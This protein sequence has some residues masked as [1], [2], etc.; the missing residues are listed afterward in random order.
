MNK[1]LA[2]IKCYDILARMSRT[3][4]H[5]YSRTRCTRRQHGGFLNEKLKEFYYAIILNNL[6]KIKKLVEEDGVNVNSLFEGRPLLFTCIQYERF[7]IAKYMIDHGADINFKHENKTILSLASLLNITKSVKFLISNGA[8]INDTNNILGNPPLYNAIFNNNKKLVTW[9]IESGANLNIQNMR[10]ETPLHCAA[11]NGRL[12]IVKMLIQKGASPNIKDNLRMT[13]LEDA[14]LNSHRKIVQYLR[15][16]TA[17]N[18]DSNSNSNNN[19][20]NNNNGP[21][22]PLPAISASPLPTTL[23]ADKPSQCFDPIMLESSNISDN[24]DSLKLY[25]KNRAGAIIKAYCIDDAL[26][27]NIKSVEQLFYQCKDKTPV[28]ALMIQQKNVHVE[29][30]LRRIMMDIPYF[31]TND[32]CQ[33]MQLGKSYLLQETDKPVG[34]IV[35]YRVLNGGNVVSAKHCGPAEPGN[36]YD[37]YEIVS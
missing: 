1:L 32:E 5:R 6:K 9:L 8:D 18:N 37:I 22:F 26:L 27:T 35:S 16:L 31:T 13:P 34:R 4:K 28:S 10:G 17:V 3:R 25:V 14:E 19:S 15:P 33:K 2:T 29:T 20:N 12:E 24:A 36:I 11:S 7:D 21:D 23:V 30:P